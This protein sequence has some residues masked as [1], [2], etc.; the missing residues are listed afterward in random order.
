[1]QHLGNKNEFK[2]LLVLIVFL[3]FNLYQYIISSQKTQDLL[4]NEVESFSISIEFLKAGIEKNDTGFIK[5]AL[6]NFEKDPPF[7]TISSINFGPNT[8][9][10]VKR[11]HNYLRYLSYNDEY[12]PKQEVE[13]ANKM[14]NILK[15]LSRHSTPEN[16]Q[17]LTIKEIE[18]QMKEIEDALR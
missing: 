7:S 12:E 14:L 5:Y 15:P 10:A 4:F 6:Y 1:M 11:Y 13:K 17:P 2:L 8:K 18:R 16:W 9:F 3:L